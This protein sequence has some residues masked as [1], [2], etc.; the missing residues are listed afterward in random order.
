MF[1]KL[2]RK[3]NFSERK[4]E[5]MHYSFE[6]QNGIFG[7]TFILALVSLGVFHLQNRVSDLF[8]FVLLR[9]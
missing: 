2:A 6:E 3:V 4:F 1:S 8:N 9:R 5:E 7:E